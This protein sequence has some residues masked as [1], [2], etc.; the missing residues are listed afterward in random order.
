MIKLESSKKTDV[1]MIDIFEIDGKT[2]QI[3]AKAKVNVSL[4]YMKNVRKHGAEY[5]AGELLEDML[6]EDA[7]DALM[8]YDDLTAEDLNAVMEAVQKV[9]LGDMEKVGKD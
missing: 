4:K 8:N 2:Y 1:E 7:Y 5:A 6:G 3:P 9:A